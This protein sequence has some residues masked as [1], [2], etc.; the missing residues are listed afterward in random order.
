MSGALHME[1][2]LSVVPPGDPQP[3]RPPLSAH[4]LH[5]PRP[6]GLT[7]C[8]PPHNDPSPTLPTQHDFSPNFPTYH[9]PDPKFPPLHSQLTKFASYHD[10]VPLL[11]P[12]PG[13]PQPHTALPG[14]EAAEGVIASVIQPLMP[15]EKTQDVAHVREPLL[16][17]GGPPAAE[18]GSTVPLQ[19]TGYRSG[20]HNLSQWQQQQL[21]RHQAVH[22]E[23]QDAV[24][25]NASCRTKESDVNTTTRH[26]QAA[27]TQD[28]DERLKVTLDKREDLSRTILSC[29]EEIVLLRSSTAHVQGAVECVRRASECS[30]EC[31]DIRGR[32]RGEDRT[33]DPLHHALL[34]EQKALH[35]DNCKLNEL[36]QQLLQQTSRLRDVKK[37]LELNWSDKQEAFQLDLSAAKLVNQLPMAQFKGGVS[38]AQGSS[39]PDGWGERV[40]NL[41]AT[42]KGEITRGGQ[43]RAAASHAVEE[44]SSD[45]RERDESVTRCLQQRIAELENAKLTLSSDAQQVLQ[46]CRKQEVSIEQLQKEL[47]AKES[48]LQ[49]AQTRAWLRGH[50]PGDDMCLDPPH[51]TLQEELRKLPENISEL[52]DKLRESEDCLA[53]LQALHAD[54]LAH[55][56]NKTHTLALEHRCNTVRMSAP[57]CD[58]LHHLLCA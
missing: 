32:R 7:E 34:Q 5:S 21:T 1:K 45:M 26:Y 43:V 44:T 35:L 47:R 12:K 2:L 11:P 3:A 58:D 4:T 54:L 51:Y 19:G 29:A 22:Q 38:H 17:Q 30:G 23:L 52:M 53:R 57:Q 48:P 39:H 42:A 18:G 16:W 37:Q 10:P 40:R 28:L 50:R 8:H 31:S 25:L 27:V 36:L 20:A 33:V 41:I 24:R 13:S 9:D 49:V 55:L 46:E 6:R 56:T 14:R 15:S